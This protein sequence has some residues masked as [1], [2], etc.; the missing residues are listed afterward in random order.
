MESIAPNAARRNLIIVG[1]LV[2]FLAVLFILLSPKLVNQLGRNPG[3]TLYAVFLNNDQVYFG[4]ISAQT[5]KSITLTNVYYLAPQALKNGVN[6]Q[7]AAL[8][9]LGN[10][11]HAP[12]DW[13]QINQDHVLFLEKLREDGKIAQAIRA[14]QKK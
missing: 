14:Y 1:S 13:L 4:T 5:N 8:L 11:L 7:D 6:A 3:S 2:V 10:E 12:E 9:K